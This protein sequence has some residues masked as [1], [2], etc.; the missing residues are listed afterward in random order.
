MFRQRQCTCKARSVV[1]AG[2]M[3]LDN[4]FSQ[5]CIVDAPGGW[6]TTGS[7]HSACEERYPSNRIL[8]ATLPWVENNRPYTGKRDF[9]NDSHFYKSELC[10]SYWFLRGQPEK[11]TGKERCNSVAVPQLY[12]LCLSKQRSVRT[13]ART[14]TDEDQH[15]SFW[16]ESVFV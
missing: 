13:P 4:P 16:C 12:C 7:I 11:E 15:A 10:L 8:G 6:C 14:K 2:P 9:E 3:D 5:E 1:T